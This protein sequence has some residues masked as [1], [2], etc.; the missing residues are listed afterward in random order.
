[1]EI[2]SRDTQYLITMPIVRNAIH[3]ILAG[4]FREVTIILDGR[5][6]TFKVMP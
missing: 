5:E 1:M 2:L 4:D 3:Q 6:I